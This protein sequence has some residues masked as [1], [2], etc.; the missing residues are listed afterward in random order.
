MMKYNDTQRGGLS[1]RRPYMQIEQNGK[2]DY[3][4]KF[5][6]FLMGTVLLISLIGLVFLESAMRNMYQDGGKSA[7]MVQILGLVAGAVIAAA[8]SFTDYY[9]FRLFSW[10]FYAANVLLMLSVFTPLGVD[11]Y[12]SRAWIDLSVTTY[13]PSE[14]MKLAMVLVIAQ[15][16]EYIERDGALTFKRAA[17]IIGSF[18]LPL[19]LVFLQKDIGQAMVFIFVFM[20]TL[21]VGGINKWFLLSL[22]GAGMLA[23]PFVWK[24]GMNDA[25]R[26]RLLS[27]IDPEKYLDYSYQL[28][29]TVTAIGSGQ[30]TGEGLGNGTM[31]NGKMIPVKMSDSIFAVI[32]EETGFIGCV[33][34]ILLMTI[35]LA[36]MI[37]IS[38]RARETFGKCVAAG[39]FAMF[40]FNIIE[41]I[42]MNIGIMP[43]TGLPLPFISK[44]GSSMVTNFMAIGVLLS[45]SMRKQNGFFTD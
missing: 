32:G 6:Y 27:F 26:G 28:R 31:N 24:F 41:N 12:G 33:F 22:I 15:Q 34:V 14:L 16:I 38:F 21:F 43:I 5:D 11:Q 40:A 3:L 19:G 2:L 18:L 36:R 42:G 29:R 20:V 23:L 25:R 35:L 44:G 13:Q 30:L 45:I 9:L 37:H 7:M 39:I 17:I 10:P 8:L 4:A 1:I